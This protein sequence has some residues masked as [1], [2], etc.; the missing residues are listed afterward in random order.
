MNRIYSFITKLILRKLAIYRLIAMHDIF[1][2]MLIRM[3]YF[4]TMDVLST[5]KFKIISEVF[6]RSIIYSEV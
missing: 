1:I 3:D 6:F 2:K 4:A 5:S